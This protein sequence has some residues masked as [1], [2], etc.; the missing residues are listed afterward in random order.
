MENDKFQ[1]IRKARLPLKIISGDLEEN[2]DDDDQKGRN[3][4]NGQFSHMITRE[5]KQ[6]HLDKIIWKKIFSSSNGNGYRD[7]KIFLLGFRLE[8]EQ[9]GAARVIKLE[10]FTFQAAN[11]DVKRKGLELATALRK[12]YSKY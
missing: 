8:R 5:K 7:D 10:I 4:S 9:D 6:F 3:L 2:Q 1:I 12:I 11:P